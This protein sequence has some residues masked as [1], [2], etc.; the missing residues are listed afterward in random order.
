LEKFKNV[1]LWFLALLAINVGGFWFSYFGTLFRGVDFAHHFHAIVMLAW[2]G[3]L[4]VQPFLIRQKRFSLHRQLGRIG[5]FVAIL[6]VISGLYVAIFGLGEGVNARGARGFYFSLFLSFNF[7]L[8]A[9]LAFLTRQNF[10][11]HARYMIAT[12]LVFIIPGFGRFYFLLLEPLGFPSLPLLAYQSVP[13][14]VSISLVI[15]DQ[16][17]GRIRVPFLLASGLWLIHIWVMSQIVHWNWWIDLANQIVQH[18]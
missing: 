1:S 9:S 7:A 10:E 6:V 2:V 16:A 12:G 5:F 13:A 15:W 17:Q 4:I 3:L 14:L 18:N 11:L 8:M